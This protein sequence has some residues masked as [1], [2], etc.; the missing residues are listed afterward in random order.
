M[1]P[2]CGSWSSSNDVFLLPLNLMWKG[3]TTGRAA[4]GHG[5]LAL[6]PAPVVTP[7]TLDR[8]RQIDRSC[9]NATFPQLSAQNFK[10]SVTF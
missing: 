5:R 9:N 4:F 6:L 2:S 8:K 1:P 7:V 10:Q 3:R